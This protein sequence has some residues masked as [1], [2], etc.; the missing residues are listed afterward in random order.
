MAVKGSEKLERT[1]ILQSFQALQKYSGAA[2]QNWKPL[3]KI[4]EIS[5]TKHW[6]LWIFINLAKRRIAWQLNKECFIRGNTRKY[7]SDW[8]FSPWA[9]GFYKAKFSLFSEDMQIKMEGETSFWVIP[10]KTT[11][12]VIL[13]LFI[14]WMIYKIFDSRFEI[15]KKGEDNHKTTSA[16]YEIENTKTLKNNIAENRTPTAEPEKEKR[17]GKNSIKMTKG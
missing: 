4:P 7:E 5:I 15:K 10:W 11:M 16:E 12:A 1:G 14:I 3:F 2:R 9:Y 17:K 6:E 13:L 8:R